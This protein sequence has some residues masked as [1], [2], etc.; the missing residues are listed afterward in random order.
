MPDSPITE[1]ADFE[2][3]SIVAGLRQSR[4]GGGRTGPR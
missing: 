3:G 2:V 1:A 4:D